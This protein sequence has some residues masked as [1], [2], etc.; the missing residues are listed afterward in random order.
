LLGGESPVEKP[1]PVRPIIIQEPHPGPVVAAPPFSRAV[2]PPLAP[3]RIEQAE[4]AVGVHAP[5]LTES[6]TAYQRARHLREDATEHLKRVGETTERHQVKVPVAHRR[7]L[8]AEATQTI[9]LIRHPATVRQAV[10]ASLIF[11][12][13]KALE[14]E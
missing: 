3:S 11:G 1:P 10:I 4:K 14:S 2:P 8:S 5:T 9:S 12:P 6:T 7:P 13:P